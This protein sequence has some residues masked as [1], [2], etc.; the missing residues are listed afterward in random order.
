[1]DLMW[2]WWH[3]AETDFSQGMPVPC[4]KV[5]LL[6]VNVLFPRGTQVP[7]I[8]P[9]SASQVL[10]FQGCTTSPSHR[11]LGMELIALRVC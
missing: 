3:P 7:L 8:P 6:L 10:I 2:F 1:M 9:V 11:M 4:L 5:L